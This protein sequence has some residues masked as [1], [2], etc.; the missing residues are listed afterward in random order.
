[1]AKE[2]IHDN[3]KQRYEI[4]HNINDHYIMTPHFHKHYEIYL[5]VS[6][7]KYFFIDGVIYDI[8]PGDLFLI[9]CNKIHQ[10][11]AS[12]KEM[13]DRYI[14]I[15]QP[16]YFLFLLSEG[17]Q[18]TSC[19]NHC[20]DKANYKIAL[21]NAQQLKLKSYFDKY[22][23]SDEYGKDVLSL[24]II[25]ELLLYINKVINLL[26]QSKDMTPKINQDNK[27][28]P[29]LS[30]IEYHLRG[31]L[32]LK[33]LSTQLFISEHYLCKI[34]LKYTG[35]TITQYI[36]QRRIAEAKKLLN[37]DIPVKNVC[38]NVGFN[39][40]SHFIRT[41]KSIVGVPPNTYRRKKGGD[42]NQ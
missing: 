3:L 5:S 21:T 14:V 39:D 13:Y 30:Y 22:E 42:V 26:P 36:I 6:G 8:N 18:L 2:I 10:V 19:F 35:T 9:P 11:V 32:S 37:Q 41:F 1:M 15:M 25:L 20:S 17:T 23:Q 28:L 33:S 40:Y 4:I 24:S 27:I 29:I 7:G 31:D 16:E 38:E 12:P 34:F